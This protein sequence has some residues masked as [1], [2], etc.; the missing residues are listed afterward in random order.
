MKLLLAENR[1]EY[2]PT[3][4]RPLAEAAR[5]AGYDVHVA[6]L[7]WG[8]AA[9][10]AEA[11]FPFHQI[12]RRKGGNRILQ[13]LA[14][15]FGLRRV[16]NQVRPDICHLFTLRAVVH[17]LV[18]FL[19]GGVRPPLVV[20][21]I[22]GLGYLFTDEG[23]QARIG[24]AVAGN[25]IGWL[26]SL[27]RPIFIFQN[28]DDRALFADRGWVPLSASC[29]VPGSG[30]DIRAFSKAEMPSGTP[31]VLFSA[32]YLRPKGIFEFVEAARLLRNEGIDARFV[33][34]G[35]VDP[36]NPAS[37]RRADVEA[38][39]EE[40]IV[41]DWGFCSD[42]PA[43]LAQASLVVLPST[44]GEGLPKVVIEAGATGR[45]VI[46][47]DSP[48]CREAIVDGETGMLVPAKDPRALARA[49]RTLLADPARL[50]LMGEA[51][52]RDVESRFASDVIANA[53]LG[54]YSSGLAPPDERASGFGN[55]VSPSA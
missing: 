42:M 10:I 40:G 14:A 2:F 51:A 38:W 44:Y 54:V 43:R 13:E 36:H 26:R 34:V 15:L 35:D 55:A 23:L 12:S 11:G 41:E 3:H 50:R 20:C 53:I 32:R 24:R 9:A 19:L 48:G 29:L 1:V 46:V 6:T 22:T 33:I 7:T 45:P 25:L 37:A 5:R 28:R 21:S 27:V 30:V 47:S 8:P 4:R 52:R 31:I 49:I 17:G 18:A 39:L 16:L